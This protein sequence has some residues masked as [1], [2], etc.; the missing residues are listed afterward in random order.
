MWLAEL[1]DLGAGF[2]RYFEIVP[3]LND[4][5]REHAYRIRHQVY[6]EDLEFEPV[7]PDRREF[8]EYDAHS[9]H[10]LIRS[11]QSGDYVGC[12]RL[13]LAR[14]GDPHYP[15]PFERACADT[16]DRSIA[17]PRAYP[18]QFIAEVSR[19]AVIAAY[20]RRRGERTLPVDI[21]DGSF[22]TAVQPRFPYIPVGLYLGTIELAALHRIETL[23]VLIE[24]RLATHFARLGVDIKQIGGA[25]EHRGT[26]LPA[27]MSV[28]GIIAGLGS[29]I[30]PLYEV[31]AVE[32]RRAVC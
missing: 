16:L 25:V 26:R 7:K 9:L 32:I 23:F 4:E 21:T 27:M 12:T 30:R 14:P 18:R 10:C 31:I 1:K 5:L 8:D 3:A 13:I 2:R 11:V 15:L 28:P 6:C 19:L 20:R 29:M 24:P 17:D 22:G